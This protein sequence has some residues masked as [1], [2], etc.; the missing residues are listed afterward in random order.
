MN[1]SIRQSFNHSL[2]LLV[3]LFLFSSLG[4]AQNLDAIK[5]QSGLS[6]EELKAKAAAAGYTPEDMYKLQRST[7]IK[8]SAVKSA[9][10]QNKIIVTPPQA[11]KSSNFA[12]PDFAGREGAEGLQAFGYNVF[13]YAATSFEPSGNVPTPTNYVVGPGDEIVV[14]LWGETQLVH[15][16]TVSKNGDIVIP[17]V[18]LVNVNGLTIKELR[19]K[20]FSVLSGAYSSLKS[21]DVNAKTR[22]DVSTGKLR[23]VKVYVLGEVNTPGGY[24]LP[25][26][27]TSFTALYYSGGPTINGSLRNVQVMRGGKIIGEVDLYEYLSTGNKTKDVKLEDED[28]VFIPPVGKR[29]AVNGNAFRTAIYEMKND[30][31]LSDLLNYAGGLKFT[32]YF[33]RVHVER[34]IPFAQRKNYENNVLSIDLNFGSADELIKSNYQLENGDVV[35]IRGVNT[36]PENRVSIS[37]YVK[38]P[39]VYELTTPGMTIKDLIIK[40]DSLQKEAFLDKGLLIR[41]LPSEKKEIFSFNVTLA[42]QGESGNNFPLMNRDEV[43][44]SN[45]QTYFPA[46]S[47][48][49]VGAV[50]NPGTFT[51][52]ENMT[53]TKL[54]TLAGG[55]TDAAT[56]RNIEITR[57][58]TSKVG[59]FS[60][61]FTADLPNEY[62]KLDPD[63]DFM[64]K[65]YDRVLV[66]TDPLKEFNRTVTISG[67]VNYPGSYTILREGEKLSNF[68]KRSGGLKET[69]Y[70]K[71]ISIVRD[72][73]LWEDSFFPIADSIIFRNQ[74]IALF[75]PALI[76]G[77]SKRVPIEWDEVIADSNSVY[78]IVL[79]PGDQL[80]V[81]RD[82]QIVNVVGDVGIPSSVPYKSG[83]KLSYYIDQA[84]KYKLTSAKGEEIVILPNGK[85]WNRSGFFLIPD[86][87]IES[88][89]RIIVPTLVEYDNTSAWAVVR[90]IMTGL[91]SAIVVILSVWQLS[92][93]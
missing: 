69:A 75:N 14:T 48:E 91:S 27:S 26:L 41:T 66:K 72:Q 85:I 86:P 70:T 56:T 89:S 45:Q 2:I 88:G 4:Q 82:P 57:M 43:R 71:G 9:A 90:D 13:N 15:N 40:A 93:L 3:L 67:E 21:S 1:H 53:L 17:N 33:D 18:G 42:L 65:D 12:V 46:R 38:K 10:E 7:A 5:Q 49:I 6:E 74:S 68:I 59:V 54:M 60:K 80:V 63:K 73:K 32:A 79:W 28:I 76:S 62:W 8:D 55:V 50:K 44:I 25:A 51:R 19:A 77:L 16:V 35:Q 37:G 83:K 36:L 61:R 92:K 81:P 78:N 22:L 20:L 11:P 39:G 52:F 29:V 64:L 58:D 47:V 34:I 31:K 23:S 30:E 84:G 87:P 24:S